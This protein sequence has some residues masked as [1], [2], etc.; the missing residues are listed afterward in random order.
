MVDLLVDGTQIPNVFPNQRVGARTLNTVKVDVSTENTADSKRIAIIRTSDRIAFKNCRRRWAWSS[1]L[2]GNLGPK[3]GISPLWFGTGIH[4]ALEDF[5][6]YNKFEH[7]TKAFMAF[8]DASRRHHKSDPN[9]LPE[10][11]DELVEL[12]KGMMDYYILWLQQRTNSLLKTYW[13]DGVPQVEVNGRF[14]IPWEK[15]KFG[16]DEVYYSFTID[17]VCIDEDGFLWPLDYK[18]AKV[19]ETLHLLTDPQV[20]AYMWLAPFVYSKPI[21]GFL[22]QQHKK[23]IP[24]PGRLIYGGSKVSTAENQSTSYIMYR[25]TLIEKYGSVDRSPEENQNYLKRLMMYEDEWKDPFIQI[26][27]VSRNERRGES[28]GAI[29]LLELEDMLNPDLPLY[30]NRTRFCLNT[31]KPELSCPF[32]SP[33][34]SLDDGGDWITELELTTDQRESNYDSWRSSLIWPGSEEAASDI[35]KAQSLDRSFLD[36]DDEYV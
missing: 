12:G 14:K 5:H 29:V 26:D 24:N 1:H 13:V 32:I 21:G 22:Y 18:T 10:D 3:H 23:S 33:C 35:Q 15:G 8:V 25:K 17:R 16:Y 30:P 2:R 19:I 4:F 31:W 11:I 27:K 20:T 28:E 9:K 6:G 34:T 36:L 7:P